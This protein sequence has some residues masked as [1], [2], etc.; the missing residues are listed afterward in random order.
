MWEKT[1]A[2]R[3]AHFHMNR[4]GKRYNANCYYSPGV[5]RFFAV[6]SLDPYTALEVAQ[7]LSGKMPGIA[8]CVLGQD[9]VIMNNEN[10]HEYTLE[11]K[12]VFALGASILFSRQIP[13]I[14]KF[15]NPSV[16]HVG[17]QLPPDYDNNENGQIFMEF[18][19]YARFVIQAWH[20]AKISEM[21][22]N[23]LPMEQYNNDFFSA[24]NPGF[25]TPA[26]NVNGQLKTGITKEI[27]KIL[28]YSNSHEEA[29]EKIAQMWR[30]N[31]TPLSI[32]WRQTFYN[33]LEIDPPVDLATVGVD[34]S[35]YSGYIL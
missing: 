8:V 6:D 17:P 9:D 7:I 16:K 25:E 31:N 19:Q 27:K 28:Y 18:K 24:L 5:D 12:Q 23:F 26:D 30:E 35:Q 22:F 4:L 1:M 2:A 34:T 32:Y 20:A 14:R 21:Q 11:E 15:A 10:C 29:L 13:A 33:F 3:T